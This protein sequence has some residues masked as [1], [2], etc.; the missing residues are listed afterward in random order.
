MTQVFI[1][2]KMFGPA[3]ENSDA[4]E[5]TDIAPL[6]MRWGNGQTI[7]ARWFKGATCEE[8]SSLEFYDPS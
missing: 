8:K 4:E 3:T 1:I 6:D 7:A 5:E 2:K